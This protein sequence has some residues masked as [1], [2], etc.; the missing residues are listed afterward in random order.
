MVAEFAGHF[1]YWAIAVLLLIGLYGI[2]AKDNLLKKLM[3]LNI[4]QASVILFFINLAQKSGSTV[5]VLMTGDRHPDPGM[6]TNPL[7]HALML[8]AVV[9]GLST[10]GVALSLLIRI[11]RRY[12]SL[13]EPEVLRKIGR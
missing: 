5:P 3:A 6:Y 4:M 12:G 13:E 1:N 10:T 8:T 7:P 11:H 9:V 2:M